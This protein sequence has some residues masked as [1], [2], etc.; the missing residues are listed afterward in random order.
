[1]YLHDLIK[2]DHTNLANKTFF[3]PKDKKNKKNNN[4]NVLTRSVEEFY[5]FVEGLIEDK[6]TPTKKIK[7]EQIFQKTNLDK[8]SNASQN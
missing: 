6:N 4:K 8:F 7:A 2:V 5:S 1:M 3:A